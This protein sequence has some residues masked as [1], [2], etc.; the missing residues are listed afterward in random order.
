MLFD[1]ASMHRLPQQAHACTSCMNLSVPP[2][3][4]LVSDIAGGD[5]VIVMTMETRLCAKQVAR[6]RLPFAVRAIGETATN[7]AC[8]TNRGKTRI[9]RACRAP[10]PTAN[11]LGQIVVSTAL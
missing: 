9:P 11:D 3:A 1:S 2:H 8:S 7:H 4:E 5:V 6:A 10:W